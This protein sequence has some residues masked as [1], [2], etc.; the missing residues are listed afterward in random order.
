MA[1]F[2]YFKPGQLTPV[3]RQDIAQWGL[4]YAFPGPVAP[5]VCTANTP[6]DQPGTVFADPTRVDNIA[7]DMPHQ[8]RW[9]KLP[10]SDIHVSYWLDAKPAP[11]DLA[12][13]PQLPGYA[14]ALADNEQWTIPLVRRFDAV[15]LETVS[16]LPTYMECDDH[17]NWHRGAVL[18]IHA[19]L[20]DVTQPIADALLSEYVRGKP[21]I[22]ADNDIMRAIV[23]LLSTNYAVGPGELTVLR[24]F[25]SEASTHA[26][27]M[28]AC[29]WP[30]FMQWH[31]EIEKKSEHPQLTA[32][33]SM[34]AGAAA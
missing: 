8:A 33:S 2:L 27:V 6:T 10:G 21:L 30:T 23:A 25:S 22:L 20:W 5:R 16:N 9:R 29:D 13:S 24:A 1:G 18:D 11:A 12:V 19:H 14:V 3:T 32:G 7:M 26:A 4:G 31:E 28:A 15:K 17:G 34:S